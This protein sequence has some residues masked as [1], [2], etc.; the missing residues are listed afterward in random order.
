MSR[1]EI[2]PIGDSR[3]E[4]ESFLAAVQKYAGGAE[5][6][7]SVSVIGDNRM[8]DVMRAQEPTPP[9][10]YYFE[11]EENHSSNNGNGRDGDIITGVDRGTVAGEFIRTSDYGLANTNRAIEIKEGQ[12]IVFVQK[13]ATDLNG[14][15]IP[16]IVE[17]F[18]AIQVEKEQEIIV[19]PG[20]FY[21]LVN[22]DKNK[23]LVVRHSGLSKK[24]SPPNNPNSQAL[25]KM[26]GFAY[27]LIQYN[28]KPAF[29]INTLYNEVRSNDFG[30]I[31]VLPIPQE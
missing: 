10:T 4:S 28:G 3:R 1:V 5:G 16:D 31:P 26:R 7:P 8:R 27:Y 14:D 6:H 30:G 15:V 23:V 19:P 21:T 9:K 2:P 12:G 13:N 29:V 20:S 22:T 24:N 17:E 18:Q 11:F 25:R